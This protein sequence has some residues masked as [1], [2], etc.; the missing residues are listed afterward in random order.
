MT[1][2]KTQPKK[3]I[4]KDVDG[5]SGIETTGHDWDGLKELNNPLPR[6]WLWV[7]FVTIIWS[8]A[9]FVL[10]PAWPTIANATKG[11]LGYTQYKELKESQDEIEM[12]QAAYLERFEKASFEDVMNDPE[13]YAFASAGGRTAFMDNC[14]TCH[15]TGATGFEG[16]PNLQ[17]DAWL[18]GGSIDDIYTT[19]KHGIRWDEDDDTRVSMMPAFGKDGILTRDEIKSVVHYVM[20]LSDKSIHADVAGETIFMENCAACHADD[21]KGLTDMGA[22]DLSDAIWL[23]GGDEHKLYETVYYARAGVMPAW[24]HRLDENTLRQISVYVHQLGG[25]E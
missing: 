18:W 11:T 23:Y 16:Y 15:G 24:Q 6:W 25:G 12:R 5:L 3:D 13:L 2:N 17:D 4:K 9:Y 1:K 21:G 22:P 7:W 8:I 20:S 19:L 14:A 10:Y